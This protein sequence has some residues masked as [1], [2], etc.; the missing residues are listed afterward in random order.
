MLETRSH[1]AGL[2]DEL[3]VGADALDVTQRRRRNKVVGIHIM[4]YEHLVGKFAPAFEIAVGVRV[5]R[6][7]EALE[8][9]VVDRRENRDEIVRQARYAVRRRLLGLLLAVGKE[10]NILVGVLRFAF[11]AELK[12][13]IEYLTAGSSV[14]FLERNAPWT[15]AETSAAV[16]R[17]DVVDGVFRAL[18]EILIDDFPQKFA[19]SRIGKTTLFVDI[20]LAV[21]VEREIFRVLLGEFAADLAGSQN[22]PAFTRAAG[23][24]TFR[25]AVE[26][27]GLHEIESYSLG[28]IGIH[29]L[30]R[31][32]RK[33]HIAAD[34]EKEKPRLRTVV[35]AHPSRAALVRE[36]GAPHHVGKSEIF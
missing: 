25:S 11:L 30:H 14:F 36:I 34:A 6:M 12:H 8:K 28:K 1:G 15:P 20:A 5:G 26:R 18:G 2:F 13:G 31:L 33:T 32:N 29:L 7:G 4:P 22:L 19:Q 9:V 16:G 3:D 24:I 21:V 27:P 17:A 10:R 23:K 35:R